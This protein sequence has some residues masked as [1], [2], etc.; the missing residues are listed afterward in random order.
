[1]LLPFNL[2]L[3]ILAGSCAQA[4]FTKAK[5]V[6]KQSADFKSDVEAFEAMLG[7]IVTSTDAGDASSSSSGDESA[8]GE[9]REGAALQSP[10]PRG[11]IEG[12]AGTDSQSAQKAAEGGPEGGMG[13][14]VHVKEE[15]EADGSSGSP[16]ERNQ[17][18]VGED[19][20]PLA[21][22]RHGKHSSSLSETGT[23]SRQSNVH[24]DVDQGFSGSPDQA[25][26]GPLVGDV[27]AVVK[28]EEA[29]DGLALA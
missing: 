25:S 26:E 5:K 27:G 6:A 14:D 2:P 19:G 22:D 11:G 8:A 20:S 13:V 15:E 18:I 10:S 24:R 7:E 29:M 21:S 12:G 16:V 28:L 23:R 1:M 9:P 17:P 4:I 3:M